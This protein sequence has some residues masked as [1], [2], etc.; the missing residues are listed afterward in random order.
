VLKQ[1][2]GAKGLCFILFFILEGVKVGKK[3]LSSV[4]QLL[5]FVTNPFFNCF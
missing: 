2:A 5:K 1:E 3:A 4:W